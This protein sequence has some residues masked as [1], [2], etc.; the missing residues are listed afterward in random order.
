MDARCRFPLG[1]DGRLLGVSTLSIFNTF[2]SFAVKLLL[3]HK[4]NGTDER[5]RKGHSCFWT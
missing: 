2:L 1:H 4:D 5:E 3:N